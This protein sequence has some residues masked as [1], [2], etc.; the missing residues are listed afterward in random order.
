[1]PKE[2]SA[3]HSVAKGAFAGETVSSVAQSLKSGDLTAADVPIQYIVRD[4]NTLIL[5]TRSAQALEQAGI[6]RS[7]WNAVNVTGNVDAERRLTNQLKS[8][9]LTSEGTPTVTPRRPNE[10]Q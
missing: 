6:P 3:K 2:T 7:E 9:N 10:N 8:S 5:N 1:M 4:G